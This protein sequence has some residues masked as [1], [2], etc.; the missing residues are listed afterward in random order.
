M[1]SWDFF[2]LMLNKSGVVCTPGEGFGNCGRGFIR[3]SAFNDF[4]NVQK[5]MQR[6]AAA[7]G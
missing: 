6:M 5:A 4:E 3:I 1:G 2:D 7:I